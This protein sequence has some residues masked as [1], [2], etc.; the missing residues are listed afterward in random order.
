MF[1]HVQPISDHTSISPSF[2]FETPSVCR[3]NSDQLAMGQNLPTMWLFGDDHQPSGSQ[4]K[5]TG[6]HD[7]HPTPWQAIKVIDDEG[8]VDRSLK[9]LMRFHRAEWLSFHGAIRAQ[10]VP[11]LR[12]VPWADRGNPGCLGKLQKGNGLVQHRMTRQKSNHPG[13]LSY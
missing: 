13:L 12:L 8:Q 6:C 1:N 5:G 9:T 4:S 7:P 10:D 11:G 3:I 2:I